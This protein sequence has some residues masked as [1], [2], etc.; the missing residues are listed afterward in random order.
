MS[1]TVDF[2]KAKLETDNRWLERG[3]LAIYNY[4]TSQ[5]QRAGD[6]IEDNGVGFNGADGQFL[7][8]IAKWIKGGCQ[9]GKQEGHRLSVKQAAV[10][11]RKMMKYAGQLVRIINEKQ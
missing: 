4:Q 5:E 9:Y 3:I 10:A 7:S 6:T 1:Y 2:I 11:R 8:S